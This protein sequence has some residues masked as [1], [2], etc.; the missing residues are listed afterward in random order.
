MFE[1]LTIEYFVGGEKRT[2]IIEIVS[3]GGYHPIEYEELLL[4]DKSKESEEYVYVVIFICDHNLYEIYLQLFTSVN[5][6]KYQEYDT[7]MLGPL[8][9]LRFKNTYTFEDIIKITIDFIKFVVKKNEIKNL[10]CGDDES[11]YHQD[12]GEYEDEGVEHQDEDEYD[13]GEYKDIDR[14]KDIAEYEKQKEKCAESYCEKKFEY[15]SSTISKDELI[16][17]DID[18][19][20]IYISNF[21]LKKYEKDNYF[22]DIQSYLNEFKIPEINQE[23]TYKEQKDIIDELWLECYENI[24]HLNTYIINKKLDDKDTKFSDM[25]VLLENNEILLKDKLAELETIS[26]VLLEKDSKYLEKESKN[27]EKKKRNDRIISLDAK[28]KEL[29]K[30]D[31]DDID[32]TYY[33]FEFISKW[34]KGYTNM[35]ATIKNENIVE[36]ECKIPLLEDKEKLEREK[37]KTKFLE[38]TKK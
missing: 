34:Y 32:F 10:A 38:H 37:E 31:H 15:D 36:L 11:V 33:N 20:S 1:Q 3:V 7:F 24:E 26:S 12:E 27:L 28:I 13:K 17:V 5:I 19:T 9:I 21:D 29:L 25:L 30:Q 22:N 4:Q 23:E 18:E 8:D 35:I 2:Q 14:D 6:D 16:K